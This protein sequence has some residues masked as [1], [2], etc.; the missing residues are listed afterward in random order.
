[1]NKALSPFWDV[2]LRT[3]KLELVSDNRTTV[4]VVK[5]S[6]LQPHTISQEGLEETSQDDIVA[7]A[8]VQ[9]SN[10]VELVW[11][12]HIPLGMNLLLNDES[13]QLKVVDFPRGR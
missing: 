8:P 4:L 5:S 7:A 3:A 12:E 10:L 2:L 1:M 13:G 11:R 9:K 6:I